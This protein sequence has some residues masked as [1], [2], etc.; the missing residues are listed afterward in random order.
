[1]SSGTGLGGGGGGDAGSGPSVAVF[2]ASLLFAFAE[3]LGFR[4]QGNGL[5]VQITDALPFVVTLIALIAAR[6]HF[7]RLLDITAAAN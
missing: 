5:P 1:M 6:K 7:A 4:L 3:G 2:G